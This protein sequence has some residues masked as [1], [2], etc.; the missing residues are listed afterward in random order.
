L[1]AT[2][3]TLRRYGKRVLKRRLFRLKARLGQGEVPFSSAKPQRHESRRTA[4]SDFFL[5][6][7][8]VTA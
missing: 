8:I 6:E 1:S 7:L 2:A 3:A 5:Y 4:S